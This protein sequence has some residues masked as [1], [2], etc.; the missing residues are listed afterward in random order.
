MT[1][2]RYTAIQLVAYG[3]DMGLFLGALQLGLTGPIWAN[4]LG[5]VGAGV[6][7]FL[8]HRSFTFRLREQ[9]RDDRQAIRYFLLLGLNVPLSSA[10]LGGLLIFVSWPVVAKF[11][12][13]VICVGATYVLS[14]KY[15]FAI[16]RQETP[17]DA[18]KN[19]EA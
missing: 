14:K 10:L 15:V 3:L 18:S 2:V 16:V 17:A 5:K 7:A 1:F 19:R 9:E 8:A 12:A 13:D 4:V 6:F 11:L